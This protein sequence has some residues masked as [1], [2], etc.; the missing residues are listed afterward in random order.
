MNTTREEKAKEVGTKRI[1]H[2]QY[3]LAR[4]LR[5]TGEIRNTNGYND[6]DYGYRGVST[7]GI[8]L[9]LSLSLSHHIIIHR[10]PISLHLLHPTPDS[11]RTTY[12]Y[13][14][15][16]IESRSFSRQSQPPI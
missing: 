15:N 7:I 16:H 6:D 10:T 4:K 5:N 14:P 12:P 3:E 9:I 2:T 1:Q 8:F 11:D 13:A